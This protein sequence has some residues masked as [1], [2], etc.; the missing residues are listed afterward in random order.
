MKPH[1]LPTA[2]QHL[3]PVDLD[4][5]N[6]WLNDISLSDVRAKILSH[7]GI[8]ISEPTLSRYN[9]RRHLA[10]Q[11]LEHEADAET[12]QHC[13]DLLNGKPIPYD[14]AGLALVE[15]RAFELA[16]DPNITPAQLATLQR[17]LS[18]KQRCA[19]TQRRLAQNDQRIAIS[20]RLAR[21]REAQVAEQ[22]AV[23]KERAARSY[24]PPDGNLLPGPE[25]YDAIRKRAEAKFGFWNNQTSTP[26]SE[27]AS[28][29]PGCE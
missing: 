25:H 6:I 16:A 17:I 12:V 20:E 23:A 4:Q 26:A 22:S 13:L 3:D 21:A 19:D 7:H 2:L 14:Q 9:K 29:L 10:E 11:L 18:Y 28:P 8:E 15:K 5:I 27:T 24:C 1:A